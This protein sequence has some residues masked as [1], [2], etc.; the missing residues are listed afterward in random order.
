MI[1]YFALSCR[2]A[3][4]HIAYLDFC[5]I[6]VSQVCTSVFEIK[7]IYQSKFPIFCSTQSINR[8]KVLSVLLKTFCPMFFSLLPKRSSVELASI[9]WRMNKSH[10]NRTLPKQRIGQLSKLFLLELPAQFHDN[11]W[12]CLFLHSSSFQKMRNVLIPSPSFSKFSSSVC[13]WDLCFDF[14]VIRF[15]L[16]QIESTSPEE[17]STFSVYFD[18][19]LRCSDWH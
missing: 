12:D 3:T 6:A 18:C 10:V 1:L 15:L 7:S 19:F 8:W 4:K 13:L 17:F 2:Y 9:L 5:E 16:C 11:L 14:F